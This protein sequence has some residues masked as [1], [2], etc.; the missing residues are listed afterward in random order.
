MDYSLL[1]STFPNKE[2]AEKL[3]ML[4]LEQ[5]L[6][7]CGNIVP[8]VESRYWWQGKIEVAQEVLLFF[9]TE[10]NRVEKLIGFIQENHS[11][12]VAEILALP[13]SKGNPPYLKWISESLK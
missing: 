12:E 9:K 5:K 3:L 8:S 10:A 2:E 13:I 1:V 11:Y 7:A 6:V 4:L